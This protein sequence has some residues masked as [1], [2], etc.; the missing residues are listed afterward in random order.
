MFDISVNDLIGVKS[1]NINYNEVV[2]IRKDI[3]DN[4]ILMNYLEKKKIHF[5]TEL[6][7]RNLPINHQLD[8]G[9]IFL[10]FNGFLIDKKYF[11]KDKVLKYFDKN[12]KI[13]K[14]FKLCENVSPV[15]GNRID[16]S[17]LNNDLVYEIILTWFALQYR[18]FRS[19]DKFIEHSSTLYDI[20]LNKNNFNKITDDIKFL[21]IMFD[22]YVRTQKG[23]IPFS[24]EFGSNIKQSLQLKSTFFIKKTIEEEVTDFITTLA[25]LYNA[26]FQ[27]INVEYIEEGE[28]DV[29]ITIFITL[30]IRQSEQFVFQLKV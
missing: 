10:E 25:S 19:V 3:I 11:V 15:S 6:K 2:I 27:V 9:L 20:D 5:D 21:S 16:F 8:I 14:Y 30:K 7:L 24:D 18:N 17:K 1:Q 29:R 23:S 26:T 12:T 4:S 13:L 22:R 28:I